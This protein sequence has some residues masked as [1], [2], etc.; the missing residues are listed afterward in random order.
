L[1]RRALA[2]AGAAG[3]ALILL[4]ISVVMWRAAQEQTR[5]AAVQRSAAQ[6]RQLETQARVAFDSSGDGLQ[7]SALFAVESLKSAW[8]VDGYIACTRAVSLL[9]LRPNV[10]QAHNT[11]VVAVAYSADARWLASEDE[12]ANL[13]IWNTI[14]KRQI[15]P[16]MQQ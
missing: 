13:V 3:V 1:R 2:A 4:A 5:I 8:T 9:P 6:A 16:E 12:D 7:R 11:R 15:V 14:A 10:R